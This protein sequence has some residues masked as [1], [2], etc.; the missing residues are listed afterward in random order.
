VSLLLLARSLALL[1]AATE[2]P[3]RGMSAAHFIYIPVMIVLGLVLGYFI[4][5]RVARAELLAERRR[6]DGRAA[7]PGESGPT[8]SKED[9]RH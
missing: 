3:D 5:A 2:G 7:R 8:P 1:Q 9:Q 6:T 4:G